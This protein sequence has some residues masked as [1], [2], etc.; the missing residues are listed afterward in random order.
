MP[1]PDPPIVGLVVRQAEFGLVQ[2]QKSGLL[3]L[4]T[5][6]IEGLAAMIRA[7][8]VTAR[9]SRKNARLLAAA[10]QKEF[11]AQRSRERRQQSTGFERRSASGRSTMKPAR[12]WLGRR[13]RW[14]G[15][16]RPK[17]MGSLVMAFK[18]HGNAP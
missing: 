5:N 10:G 18:P 15:E 2:K 4:K 6:G 3:R 9:L 13:L 8:A 11:A 1:V 7:L 12:S 14:N 16:V 17:H